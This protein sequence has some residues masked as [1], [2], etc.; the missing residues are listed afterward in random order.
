[1]TPRRALVASLCSVLFVAC[2]PVDEQGLPV[3]EEEDKG[4]GELGSSTH[5]LRGGN[6]LTSN[7]LTSNALT[8]NALT[9]TPPT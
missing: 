3:D 2:V 8:S 6:A 1:M 5:A 7:A 4:K 9:S